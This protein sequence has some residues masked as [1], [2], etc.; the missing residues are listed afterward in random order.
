MFQLAKFTFG[1]EILGFLKINAVLLGAYGVATV[2]A[3]GL[4]T[5]FYL[6]YKQDNDEDAL[7]LLLENCTMFR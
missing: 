2:L 3:P 5:A 7:K 4:V 6:N 1:P